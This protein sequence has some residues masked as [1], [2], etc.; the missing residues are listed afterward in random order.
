VARIVDDVLSVLDEEAA[1]TND[2]LQLFTNAKRFPD[3]FQQVWHVARR[4]HDTT[5][6]ALSLCL[7]Q[8]SMHWSGNLV[9]ITP[10]LTV[11]ARQRPWQKQRPP[12]TGCYPTSGG[13]CV[14]RRCSMC[15]LPTKG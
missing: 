1:R 11:V 4:I 10:I 15:T 8:P 3:V 9:A 7:D 13:A 5:C 2:K 6:H 12:W 14:C